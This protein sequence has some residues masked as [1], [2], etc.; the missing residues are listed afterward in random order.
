M[1]DFNSF[2]P[3]VGAHDSG[4]E[5]LLDEAFRIVTP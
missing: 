3:A 1:E 4:L 2:V 5:M